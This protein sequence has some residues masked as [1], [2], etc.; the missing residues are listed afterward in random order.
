MPT[1][2]CGSTAA[3]R[4]LPVSAMALRCRGATKPATPV[5]AKFCRV[6]LSSSARRTRRFSRKRIVGIAKHHELLTGHTVP[7]ERGKERP[8]IV[9]RGDDE[10]IKFDRGVIGH[11]QNGMPEKG[12]AAS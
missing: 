6:M 9:K 4:A 3:T 1:A 12:G 7:L 8:R 2:S 11:G 5:I 10:Q